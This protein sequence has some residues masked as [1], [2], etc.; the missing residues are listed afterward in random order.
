MDPRHTVKNLYLQAAQSISATRPELS[1]AQLRA[2]ARQRVD[3]K[4]AASGDPELAAAW[5]AYK[6]KNRR[7]MQR[8]VRR[9][10]NITARDEHEVST[11]FGYPGGSGPRRA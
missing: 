4:V 11:A 6:L 2:A 8:L 3:L 9:E 1:G 5:Q 7:T 10:N